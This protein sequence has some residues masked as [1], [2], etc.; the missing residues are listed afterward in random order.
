VA[1]R[2]DHTG[3]VGMTGRCSARVA[4]A[5]MCTVTALVGCGGGKTEQTTPTGQVRAAVTRV[6][7]DLQSASRAGDGRHICNGIFTVKLAD[8]ITRSSASGSCEKEVRRNLFSPATRI[9]VRRVQVTDAAN[10][11]AIVAEQ[12]GNTSKVL[13]IKQAGEWRI[14]G[15]RAA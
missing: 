11:S 10:A 15:V 7:A 12:N 4:G 14:R 6:L 9:T 5:V 1:D 2:P 3:E 13:L 8:S